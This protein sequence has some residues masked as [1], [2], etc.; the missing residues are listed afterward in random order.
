M[1][2][3]SFATNSAGSTGL[4]TLPINPLIVDIP[5]GDDGGLIKVNPIINGPPVLTVKGYD[6]RRASLIWKGFS[7]DHTV[8]NTM[9]TTLEGYRWSASSNNTR[10]IHLGDIA[11]S[12]GW[13][14]G[15]T[16]EEIKILSV[17]R[18][19]ADEGAFKYDTTKLIFVLA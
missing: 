5:F 3:I 9:I 6:D 19:F 13:A 1:A 2:R 7:Q 4:Y 16:Y 12:I 14:N 15:E 11:S 17:K 8:F 18:V 10:F